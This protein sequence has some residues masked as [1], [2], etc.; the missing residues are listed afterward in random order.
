MVSV[1][2][3]FNRA[4]AGS[5]GANW[6]VPA[7]S[8]KIVS[9]QALTNSAVDNVAIHNTPLVT[10]ACEVSAPLTSSTLGSSDGVVC[11]A[12]S[13][14]VKGYLA[15]VNATTGF[16][17]IRLETSGTTVTSLGTAAVVAR[18][19]SD[20]IK[21]RVYSYGANE[22]C[23]GYFGRYVQVGVDSAAGRI[24]GGSGQR[25]TGLRAGQVANIPFSEFAA[26][27]LPD[28]LVLPF[29][30]VSGSGTVSGTG[31]SA[32]VRVTVN[33]AVPAGTLVVHRTSLSWQAG[34]TTPTGVDSK[35]NTWVGFF[36][37]DTGN[38]HGIAGIYSILTTALAN[39][40]TIDLKPGA[41]MATTSQIVAPAQAWTGVASVAGVIDK[42][43]G[44]TASSTTHSVEDPLGIYTGRPALLLYG[45]AG[46]VANLT[47]EPGDTT[48]AWTA[49]GTGRFERIEQVEVLDAFPYQM[50][51]S[52]A[53][54][55]AG[56]GLALI[57]VLAATVTTITGTS[58]AAGVAPSV[59][60]AAS[61]AGATGAAPAAGVVPAV[62]SAATI[63]AAV[64]TSP[65]AGVAPVVR[66]AQTFTATI[67]TAPAAGIAAAVAAA[68]TVAPSTGTAPA[69]GVA[70]VVT[71]GTG[72][73]PGTVTATTGTAP[74]A[75]V[76]AVLRGA[77]TVTAATATAPAAG[78]AAPAQVPASV[79]AA[80]G[81]STAAGV[82]AVVRASASVGAT[83]QATAAGTAPAVRAAATVPAAGGTAPAAGIA[84]VVF[85]AAT[86]TVLA[87][88]G[89]ALAAGIPVEVVLRALRNITMSGSL[90]APPAR[91]GSLVLAGRGGALSLT[92]R[93]G[94][95]E[96]S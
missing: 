51:S 34:F 47:S 11:R 85:G 43:S 50:I 7:G 6:S 26:S 59:S 57:P 38:A 3:D 64:G 49:N 29:G 18:T 70:P 35:G 25:Y 19:S 88:T 80:V 17:T 30:P 33:R 75:G 4:D 69:T 86:A 2:D 15:R 68:S 8:W 96:P 62:R 87:A 66:A 81:T 60:V 44:E 28:G 74:A 71:G 12:D 84:P 24:T 10:D 78:L 16:Q 31:A 94:S 67:G 36:G 37:R 55:G 54:I 27:D 61:V 65:A 53:S 45:I 46:N 39:A 13:A 82:A 73:T 77:A 32:Q 72:T 9:N 42:S 56:T 22:V 14:L 76:S 52:V 40:D 58:T 20:R 92:I 63:T 23:V 79:T 83:G 93:T 90:A 95:L 21:L 91:T 48:V 5:L 89:A 1:T 41:T